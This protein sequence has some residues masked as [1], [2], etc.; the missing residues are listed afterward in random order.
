[1]AT[2]MTSKEMVESLEKMARD[3]CA[4]EGVVYEDFIANLAQA[5][6]MG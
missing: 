3:V 1:M 4:Q 2:I 6:G 5:L